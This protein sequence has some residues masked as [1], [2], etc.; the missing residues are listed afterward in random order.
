MTE[1]ADQ[2]RAREGPNE[3]FEPGV[4]NCCKF[5]KYNGDPPRFEIF[6]EKHSK[7]VGSE[8]SL[9]FVQ[10]ILEDYKQMCA[11]LT[12]FYKFYANLGIL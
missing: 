10:T 3:K 2:K 12:S 8:I 7:G 4:K 5:E 9:P 6:R 11:C 1:K